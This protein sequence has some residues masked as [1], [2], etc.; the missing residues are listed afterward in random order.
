MVV[1]RGQFVGLFEQVEGMVA[2]GDSVFEL[3]GDLGF[4]FELSGYE[5]HDVIDHLEGDVQ[6]EDGV[7]S[8]E[9]VESVLL[10]DSPEDELF[11][12]GIAEEELLAEEGEEHLS[13]PVHVV[14]DLPNETP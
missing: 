4:G 7:G 14:K 8:V 5:F 6:G 9:E 13:C 10:F 11:L 12:V 3:V 2:F 1:V